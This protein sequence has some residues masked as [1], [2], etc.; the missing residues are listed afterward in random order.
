MRLACK[1]NMAAFGEVADEL[2][3][4]DLV[5]RGVS[6]REISD[7]YRSQYP[8]IR[9][10]TER[11]VRRYCNERSIRRISNDE[12]DAIVAQHIDLYGHSYG[13][14]MMQGS[15]RAM[16]G[17]TSG[18][19]SQRRISEASRRVAPHAFQA[20]TYDTLQRTN[21]IPYFAPY[22]GYKGHFDQNEKVA[23]TFG[24]TH[25]YFVDGCSRFILGSVTMPIKNPILIYEHLFRPALIKYGLFEQ[26]RMDHGREFVLC[27]FIQEL[28]KRYRFRQ[29][30]LPW[31]QTPSTGNYVSER[32]WPEVNQ[33]INYP[34]KR[35]LCEIQSEED[36]DFSHPL[37]MF[38]VSWVT[39]YVANDATAH[40]IRSW[41]HHRIPGPEGCVP[42]VNMAQ[43]SRTMHLP[44]ELIPTVSEAVRMYEE[45]GGFLS[46]DAT[47]GI[48]PLIMRPD[49]IESRERLFFSAQP[50]G[51]NIFADVVHGQH[52]SLK[53][54]IIYFIE[55]TTYLARFLTE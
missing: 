28:L 14:R 55:V 16:L 22:F 5:I 45:R 29:N 1:T 40:L 12:L 44:T 49:L 17:I 37:S 20:R 54:A 52:Q 11:S 30:R 53:R 46:R 38:C 7:Y 41:N 36:I 34:I 25:V 13:R 21:P 9:G 18:G 15:I 39:M 6:Y 47:F 48:D 27:I 24:M 2:F 8:H 35:Q 51:Q 43:T 26:I 31:R 33:R 32:M 23:Q 4:R 50:S 3:V 42:V 19:V 10:L